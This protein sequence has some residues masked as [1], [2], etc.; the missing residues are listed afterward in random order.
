[1]GTWCEW[2]AKGLFCPGCFQ[3]SGGGEKMP[4]VGK[5]NAEQSAG[6]PT[7]MC[8][9]G[10]SWGFTRGGAEAGLEEESTGWFP[11]LVRSGEGAA[12]EGGKEGLNPPMKELF[13][14]TDILPLSYPRSPP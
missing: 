5:G 1:M 6:R 11:R 3:A 14:T 2:R 8:S 12:K 4:E 13:P 9:V 7:S 10:I